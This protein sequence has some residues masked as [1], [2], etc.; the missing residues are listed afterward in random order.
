PA[1]LHLSPTATGQTLAGT[2][3][4]ARK[5]PEAEPAQ[6]RPLAEGGHQHPDVEL[7]M[8]PAVYRRPIFPHV[9]KEVFAPGAAVQPVLQAARY[10]ADLSLHARHHLTEGRLSLLG[11]GHLHQRQQ[12]L[13]LRL[14]LAARRSPHWRPP[15]CDPPLR[16]AACQKDPTGSWGF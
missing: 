7:I 3:A 2:G 5:I 9:E 13:Q 8:Q 10:G 15:V 14:L 1:R 4:I 16:W 6:R 12:R 11:K